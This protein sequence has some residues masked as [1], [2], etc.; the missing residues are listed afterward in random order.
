M[1]MPADVSLMAECGRPFSYCQN[2]LSLLDQSYEFSNTHKASL[3]NAGL[4]FIDTAFSHFELHLRLR[5]SLIRLY[6][7]GLLSITSLYLSSSPSA[8]HF[9]T[10]SEWSFCY[11]QVSIQDLYPLTLNLTETASQHCAPT[12]SA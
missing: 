12:V 10:S 8:L 11:H 1:H 9:G 4:S 2:H 5:P 6:L 3:V 7:L